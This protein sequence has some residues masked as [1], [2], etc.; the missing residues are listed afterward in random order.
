MEALLWK[1]IPSRL[2]QI[3]N[4][5]I[6][7]SGLA[8]FLLFSAPGL[9]SQSAGAETYAGHAGSPDTSLLYSLDYVCETAQAYGAGGR[10]AYV[11]SR[12]SLDVIR[13]WVYTLF[14]STAISRIY[15]R[16][17][18]PLSR[19]QLA[20][21][22][23][24]FGSLA[25]YLENVSASVVML[26]YPDRTPVMDIVAPILTLAKWIF[27]SGSYALLLVGAM[28]G[29]WRGTGEGAIRNRFPRR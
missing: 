21:L 20:T 19:W 7:M 16:A 2:H 14:L 26:R 6:T 12:L 25:D 15:L 18:A 27:L 4:T 13:P 23:P 11:R 29:I 17:F 8:V 3:S 9:P 5:W 10:T 24:V 22:A 1:E 28:V